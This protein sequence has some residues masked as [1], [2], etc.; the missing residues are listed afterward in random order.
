MIELR[1]YI[2]AVTLLLMGLA[3]PANADSGPTVCDD[4]QVGKVLDAATGG[5]SGSFEPWQCL[6]GSS[7]SRTYTVSG[8]SVTINQCRMPGGGGPDPW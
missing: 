2:I 4:T 7:S 8:F 5:C 6:G 3:M 1:V